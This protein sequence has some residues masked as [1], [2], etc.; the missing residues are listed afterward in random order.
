MIERRQGADRADHDRHRMRVAPEPGE[1]ARH[2][3]VQH[4]VTRDRVAEGGELVRRRQ[5]AVQEQ[6]A[7]LKEARLLGQ[8]VDGVAAIEQHAI[9]AIDVGD[10]RGTVGG[11]CEPGIVG[12]A[13]GVAVELADVDHVGA[14]RAAAHWQTGGLAF[15]GQLG[16]DFLGRFVVDVHGA[17][18]CDTRLGEWVASTRGPPGELLKQRSPMSVFSFWS[19]RAAVAAKIVEAPMLH[20]FCS[21]T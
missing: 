14:E 13:A 21:A 8:L 5:V 2:L 19:R 4:G 9:V 15:E 3:L 7:D 1:E 20:Y 16:G 12:E 18:S 17:E 6:V 10:A 11:R